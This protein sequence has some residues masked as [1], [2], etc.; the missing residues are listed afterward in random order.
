M[1]RCEKFVFSTLV[2]LKSPTRYIK[3][4]NRSHSLR[5][6]YCS[7]TGTNGSVQPAGAGGAGQAGGA[8]AQLQAGPHT[9][10]RGAHQAPQVALLL[11]ARQAS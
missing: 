2:K 4:N 9:R 11:S 8:A 10:P 1:K 5:C 6:V 7:W 3:T